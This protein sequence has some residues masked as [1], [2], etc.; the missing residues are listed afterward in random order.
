[1]YEKNMRGITS[2]KIALTF[3][4]GPNLG[5]TVDVLALLKKYKI[6]ASFFI[7]GNLI[8]DSTIKVLKQITESGCELE[9]HSFTHTF[10]THLTKQEMW[11]ETDKTSNLIEEITGRRPRFFRPP[12][13]DVNQEMFDSIPLVFISGEGVEDWNDEIKAEE[14]V[15]R[16]LTKIRDGDIVLL[17][18]LE[19][20]METVKA[21]EEVIPEW[22]A[23]GYEFVTVAE[24]FDQ[25]N[26]TP[27]A[28][29][30]ILYS[31]INDAEE[32]GGEQI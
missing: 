1:M 22:I 21:L 26:K 5:T 19:G 7:I 25:A 16:L 29:D 20:N 24:L 4:D 28:Q 23:E 3:D 11:Y 9:N 17:H 27:K 6:K 18:D 8:N 12:Y 13:I 31:N 32:K 14:R 30:G 10:M 15:S 2:M